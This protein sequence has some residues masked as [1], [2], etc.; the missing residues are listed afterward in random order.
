MRGVEQAGV[1]PSAFVVGRAAP[2]VWALGA[3]L[4]LRF[5]EEGEGQGERDLHLPGGR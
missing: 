2:E 1:D 3:E 5:A 4:V